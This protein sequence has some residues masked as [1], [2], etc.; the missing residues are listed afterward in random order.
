MWGGGRLKTTNPRGFPRR[1]APQQDRGRAEGKPELQPSASSLQGRA[2]VP[3]QHG[4]REQRAGPKHAI[5]IDHEAAAAVA[6]DVHGVRGLALQQ[7]D[8]CPLIQLIIGRREAVPTPWRPA[9]GHGQGLGDRG[10]GATAV[11]GAGWGADRDAGTGLTTAAPRAE[12][13]V[14]VALGTGPVAQTRRPWQS[15][16]QGQRGGKVPNPAR[17][18]RP[19][20]SGG[21]R[22]TRPAER[23]RTREPASAICPREAMF[24]RAAPMSAPAARPSPGRRRRSWGSQTPGGGAGLRTLPGSQ[25][26]PSP[27]LPAIVKVSRAWGGAGR[28]APGRLPHTW[29]GPGASFQ[30]PNPSF[31]ASD[32]EGGAG[33]SGFPA[34]LGF[35]PLLN[36]H[37]RDRWR[38]RRESRGAWPRVDWFIGS[39]KGRGWVVSL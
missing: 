25:S 13:G 2:H 9:E 14:R 35:T 6:V 7:R 19:L 3:L 17:I 28:R 24:P 29:R 33:G 18:Q 15:G 10:C 8:A 12:G 32:C 31:G 1:P 34:L 23:G 38:R 37:P 27:R 16:S 21:R 22:A 5:S 26:R 39:A 20:L 4:A 11:G 36:R 30:A